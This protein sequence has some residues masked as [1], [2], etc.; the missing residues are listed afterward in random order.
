MNKGWPGVGRPLLVLS[1]VGQ[2]PHSHMEKFSK[3]RREQGLQRHLSPLTEVTISS[4]T[5]GRETAVR[6]TPG[7]WLRKGIIAKCLCFVPL[8]ADFMENL[9]Q[10]VC[11]QCAIKSIFKPG[12]VVHICNPSTQETAAGGLP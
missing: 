1:A 11:V 9:V 6:C 3:Q 5:S 10:M 8:A 4:G 12:M 7:T 2:Q